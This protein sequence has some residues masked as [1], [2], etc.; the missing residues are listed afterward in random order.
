M[1]TLTFSVK[2][3][4]MTHSQLLQLLCE[5]LELSPSNITLIGNKLD[6][7]YTPRTTE[8][9]FI[10]STSNGCRLTASRVT[11]I[12]NYITLRKNEE[13]NKLWNKVFVANKYEIGI[14]TPVK[15]SLGFNM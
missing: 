13:P 1:P 12:S 7:P 2:F 4:A 14:R 10:A 15:H 5:E 8:I 11:G 9:M 6:V 3:G